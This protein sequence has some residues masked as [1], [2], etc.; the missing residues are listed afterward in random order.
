MLRLTI[1]QATA[2]GRQMHQPLGV[3]LKSVVLHADSGTAGRGLAQ[4]EHVIGGPC[5][6][7]VLKRLI[8]GTGSCI[9]MLGGKTFI[10]IYMTKKMHPAIVIAGPDAENRR[11]AARVLAKFENYAAQ[12]KG[13]VVCIEGTRDYPK[14]VPC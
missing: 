5:D 3:V 4:H 12:L 11:T 10:K 6:N 7:D 2:K 13:G 1:A 9:E 8:N 14:V